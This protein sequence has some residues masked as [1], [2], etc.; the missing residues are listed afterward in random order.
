MKKVEPFYKISSHNNKHEEAISEFLKVPHT[1]EDTEKYWA[2]RAGFITGYEIA[3]QK[4][5]AEKIKAQIDILKECQYSEQD[6]IV[7]KLLKQ[8]KQ[9]EDG[10]N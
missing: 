7:K 1:I 2:V 3:K 9:L 4:N 10:N 5:E 6:A 8:L